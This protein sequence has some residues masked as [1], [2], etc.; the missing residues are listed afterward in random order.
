M[1]G[2]GLPAAPAPLFLHD[3]CI[4]FRIRVVLTSYGASSTTI[5]E[6][7]CSITTN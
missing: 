1:E 2:K 4:A 3:P 6:A 7:P 5:E